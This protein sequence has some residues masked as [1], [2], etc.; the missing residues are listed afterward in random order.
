PLAGAVV[1]ADGIG[2]MVGQLTLRAQTNDQGQYRLPVP[3]G[4]YLVRAAYES[5][6]NWLNPV[7]L[8]AVVPQHGAATNVDLQ[9]RESDVTLSGTTSIS[10]TARLSDGRVHI[11]AFSDDGAATKTDVA[12]G[13]AYT[14]NLISNTTWHIGAVVELGNNFY[15]TRETVEMGGGNETLDLVLTGPHAMPGPVVVTFDAAE[16]VE[17]ALA[18][19]TEIYIPAGAMPVSG[20][21]TLHITPIATFPHQ[22]HARL[23]KYGYAFIATDETGAV[24][25]QNFNQN[26]FIRFSYDEAELIRLGLRERY[27]K[28]AYYSTTTQSWTIPESYVVDADANL[29]T[30]QIDHFTDFSLLN[31]SFY[32]VFLPVVVR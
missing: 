22:H 29:V 16:P 10:T 24:I 5:D 12:L 6:Q 25:T 20:T 14:L 23:Y 15:V 18:D 8:T 2:D 19:G 31:G 27:L 28:P 17:L 4:R 30:L 11:W 3:H 13:D 32:E 7:A 21:V 9:F 26:V 1:A